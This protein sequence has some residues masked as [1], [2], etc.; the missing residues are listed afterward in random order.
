MSKRPKPLD[1]QGKR[2]VREE[3]GKWEKDRGSEINE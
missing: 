2:K 1:I 3:E